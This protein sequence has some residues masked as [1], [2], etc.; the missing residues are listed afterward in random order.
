MSR[1]PEEM[2][3]GEPLRSAIQIM[4]ELHV[5]HIPV[6]KGME[7]FG[8]LSRQDMHDACLR[9]GS[10]REDRDVGDVCTRDVLTVTPLT[11]I[12][13]VARAMVDR[14]ITSAIVMDGDVLV[15][16]FTSTDALRVLADA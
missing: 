8:I 6:M 4:G 14:G 1:L 16:I 10:T 12:P 5:R 15:G 3:H 11:K 13:E 9:F 2:D 7:L